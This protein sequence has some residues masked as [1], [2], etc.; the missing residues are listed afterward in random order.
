MLSFSQLKRHLAGLLL[1]V[2]GDARGLSVFDISDEGLARSFSA[3]LWTLPVIAFYGIGSWL[4]E[5]GGT[6]G[7]GHPVA[8][9]DGSLSFALK[10]LLNEAAGIVLPILVL[11]LA[12]PLLTVR[13]L[14]RTLI[15]T[16]NWSA[17]VYLPL[18][19]LVAAPFFLMNL[20]T[21]NLAS[22]AVVVLALIGVGV[23]LFALQ[24]HLLTTVVGGDSRIRLLILLILL[25]SP[26]AML[27]LRTHLSS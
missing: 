15:V 18:V 17:L 1:L 6:P 7:L 20:Q 19:H 13:V 2:R 21:W 3:Y 26:L 27:P 10:F 8:A 11:S 12:S 4:V 25:L 14:L 22:L 24:W 16:W 23:A 5:R 9:L